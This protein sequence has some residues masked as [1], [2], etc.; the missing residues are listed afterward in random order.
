MD[1]LTARQKF[2][3]NTLFEIH[4]LNVKE[5]SKRIDVS[6]RTIL[7]EIAS[8]NI[9][10]EKSN[11]KIV[12]KNGSLIISGK[13]KEINILNQS[14]GVIP[15]QW[16]L[17]QEQRML[18]ITAELLLSDEPYKS[19]FFSYQLNVVEGTIS[20][21][22]DKI[23]QWL[24]V[25]NL[26]FN[27]KNGYGILVIGSE[28]NKRNA[29]IELIYEYK[30]V[31]ELLAYVYETKD[32]S[33]TRSFFKIL[34]GSD[35]IEIS[36]KIM[37]FVNNEITNVDDIAYL[38][39]LI[40]IMI[41]I[42]KTLENHPIVLPL[43]FIQDVLSFN[44]FS[45]SHKLQGFLEKLNIS[46]TD[47]EIANISIHLLGNKYI[48][49]ADRKFE[50]LGVTLEDLAAEVVY[51][52]EKKL[53]IIINFDNQLILGLSNHFN[54]A[55]YRIN[56]G[57]TIKNPIVDQVK[58]Y[59]GDLF[60]AVDYACKLV[61]LKYN[62]KMSKDEIGFVT[63]HIGAAIERTENLKNKLSV[64][65]ICPNGMGAAR[66][67][68]SK[69]KNVIQGIDKVGIES[70]KDW[71]ENDT[72]YDIILSTVNID[73][74]K[75]LPDSN[76]II[77]S[78]FLNSEDISKINNCIKTIK[79]QSNSFDYVI[80]LAQK[81]KNE[82]YE[83]EKYEMINNM[84]KTLQIETIEA[85]S[86]DEMVTLITSK[87]YDKKIIE[88][89]EEIKELIVKREK[90]GSVAIPNA[91]VALLHT[92]SDFVVSPFVGVYR[93]KKYMTI[94]STGFVNEKVD[95]FIVLL[96]RKS[97]QPYILEEMGNI[98]ISLI[99]NKSF[100]E[101]LRIGDIKDLRDKMVKIFNKQNA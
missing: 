38:T 52:V 60:N 25:R 23:K 67:L 50:E 62:I 100:T 8:M 3:F 18:L 57:I 40:H 45:Y 89:K 2:I 69:V 74:N 55:I 12:V 92:R 1:E 48:Y 77:V 20:L 95:T 81:D 11:I 76:I 61:F 83:E 65:V 97:E 39:S 51:E 53:D 88:N 63:M 19:S 17:T 73:I 82:N 33:G 93:L 34:F 22:M 66:I 101:T 31:E 7:R 91:H 75:N 21:Y 32:D 70:L 56:M 78:P 35:V 37:T 71:A 94:Q 44:E 49:N 87:I 42:K 5:L 15:K 29:L 98:S 28:W 68:A 24:A 9:I 79:E 59:Y 36:K 84:I 26:S 16:L 41:A 86:F 13:D 85:E 10:L 6:A 4:T 46:I 30:P 72:K 64:L 99:E 58:E 90:M 14:L 43:E 96:A 27:R 80:S 47:S 54:P